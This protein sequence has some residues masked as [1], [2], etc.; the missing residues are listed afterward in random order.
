MTNARR[1]GLRLGRRGAC[2]LLIGISWTL[3]G[4]GLV[5]SE[6]TFAQERGLT[7]ITHV[8]PLDTWA[9]LW[10][11]GGALGIGMSVIRQDA[12]G[13]VGVVLPPLTWAVSYALAWWPLQEYGRGWTSAVV[14]GAIAGALFIVSG[15]PEIQTGSPKHEP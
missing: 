2:L 4:V 9:W 15:T 1:F 3:Y 10:I 5:M 14:W 12:A 13:Y 8:A 6:P 7:A 11:G